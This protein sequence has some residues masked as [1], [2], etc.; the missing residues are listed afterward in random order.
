MLVILNPILKSSGE[1]AKS[2]SDVVSSLVI[3]GLGLAILEV[4]LDHSG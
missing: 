1:F 2:G 3:K 4:L